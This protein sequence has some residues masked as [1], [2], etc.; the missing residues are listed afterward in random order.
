M[1]KRFNSPEWK[2]YESGDHKEDGKDDEN[3]VARFS[4]AGVVKHLS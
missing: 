2:D 3:I 1:K 4:P